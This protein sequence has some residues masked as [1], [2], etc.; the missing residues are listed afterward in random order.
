MTEH[1]AHPPHHTHV[2]KAIDALHERHAAL[3]SHHQQQA[4][5]EAE[6][7]AAAVAEQTIEAASQE[8]P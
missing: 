6:R 2:R 5:A 3:R 8:Q 4:A 7:R 1:R